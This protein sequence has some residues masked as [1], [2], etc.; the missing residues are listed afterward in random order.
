[1]KIA[2]IQLENNVA[3]GPMAGVTDLTFR[4]L[5]KEQQCGLLY[6]EM[7]SA[8]GICYG[9]KNTEE[10]LAILPEERPVALQIFGS[11]PEFMAKAAEKL[12]RLE[13]TFLD[14]NMGCP[15]PKIVKNGDGSA[16]MKNPQLAGRIVKA[17]VQASAK[18]VTVKIRKGWDDGHINAVEMAKI[19]EENGAKAIAVHGRTR[20]EFYSGK[21]D[22]TIIRAVKKAVS[23]PV[24]GNG[25]V[26]TPEAG[27]QMMDET[28]CDGIMIARGAQGNPWIFRRTA[29]Y[30]K[31]GELLSEPSAEERIRMALR[32]LQLMVELKGEYIAMREMRKHI[33]WY[34]KGIRNAAQIRGQINTISTQPEMEKLLLDFWKSL[35]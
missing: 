25:D 29:H 20:E 22:W 19:L 14:I 9:D 12:N 3:L 32:H 17:V 35:S 27:K 18:P 30:L 33:P 1:M 13:H 2:G 21:A 5:C 24:I 10:L 26:Y 6:T 15:T 16:L 31:T 8:K 28:G 11:D 7:V 4:L 34:L 23:V